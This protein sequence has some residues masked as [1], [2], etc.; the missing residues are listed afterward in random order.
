MKGVTEGPFWRISE[1]NASG[2]QPELLS[3]YDAVFDK[4]TCT[5]RDSLAT[6]AREAESAR[7]LMAS[8]L[9]MCPSARAEI[10]SDPRS[11]ALPL[12]NLLLTHSSDLWATDPSSAIDAASLATRVA[13]R[14][15]VARVGTA[16]VE[17]ARAK[18]W[19]YLGNGWRV[20]GVLPAAEKSFR[21][22]AGH[23]VAAGGDPL[24]E[25]EVL[26]FIASLRDSQG[27]PAAALP[28]ID[29]ACSLYR[30]IGDRRRE[31][32]CL[33]TKGTLLGNAGAY[34]RGILSTRKGASRWRL[35]EDPSLFLGAQHNQI[36][37]LAA[38][39]SLGK[40]GRLLTEKRSLYSSF[41]DWRMLLN[42][43]LLDGIIALG[44]GGLAEAESCFWI[45]AEGFLERRF[46]LDAAL[47]LW[48]IAEIC[49][50]SGS[51]SRAKVLAA[52]VIP[53]FEEHGAA[54]DAAA[55]RQLFS[56]MSSP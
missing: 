40:A 27:R 37:F 23:L 18:A 43:R 36:L 7:Q 35:E 49:V 16:T 25:A 30:E 52:E 31:G 38:A 24:L 6:Y 17:E 10:L 50:L 21:I 9:T 2:M 22:A 8:L 20:L 13:D 53:I 15:E 46:E 55:A 14:L 48:R 5:A 11:H 3:D 44:L 33:I 32:R 39:G 41:G 1:D 45:A 12:V 54:A 47:A 4:M 19:A 51:Q 28:L 34:R 56:R 29:R 26:S 42:L